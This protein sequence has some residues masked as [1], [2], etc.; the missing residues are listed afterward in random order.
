MATQD[1]T[2][3]DLVSTMKYNIYINMLLVD[4]PYHFLNIFLFLSLIDRRHKSQIK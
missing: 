3:T 4:I 1:L 2:S